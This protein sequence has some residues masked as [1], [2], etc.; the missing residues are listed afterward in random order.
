MVLDFLKIKVK[1]F[2]PAPMRCFKCQMFGHG[3]NSCQSQ[4]D[5][6]GKCSGEHAT[7]DCDVGMTPKCVN[8]SLA[9]ASNSRDCPKFKLEQEIVAYRAKERVDYFEAKKVVLRELGNSSA[10]NR[11]FA[12]V[13]ANRPVVTTST[14]GCQ[15]EFYW[16]TTT[17]PTTTPPTATLPVSKPSTVSCSTSTDPLPESTI[18]AALSETTV[19]NSPTIVVEPTQQSSDDS[20]INSL[21][22]ELAQ[23]ENSHIVVSQTSSWHGSKEHVLMDSLVHKTARGRSESPE[24]FVADGRQSGR[25]PSADRP[26]TL[27]PNRKR[28][29]DRKSSS[30]RKPR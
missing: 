22:T 20:A 28:H 15:T 18:S 9:H 2:I 1:Q 21:M 30:D 17:N 4:K 3:T 24:D 11:S 19:S 7:K 29:K 10:P 12:S 25:S 8:C 16:V 6:C 26:P 23:L 5:I 14:I 13:V 27:S